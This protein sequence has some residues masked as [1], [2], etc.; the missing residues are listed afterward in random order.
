MRNEAQHNSH[1]KRVFEICELVLAAA[2]GKRGELLRDQ[3][4]DDAALLARVKAMLA[5]ID[6]AEQQESAQ[7]ETSDPFG[8]LGNRANPVK[9][10]D[11]I[12][13]FVLLEHIGSGG[14]GAVFRAERAHSSNAQQVAIKV[15]NAQI[16]TPELRL[17]F[18]I[19][20][21]ILSRLRHPY[22]AG[23]IDGGTI[24][25]G[26][27]YLAME[28]VDGVP[29]DVFCDN[30]R[31][32]VV[33]RLALLEKVAQALQHAHQSLVVHRDIKPSNILVTADG[34]PKLVDFGIAK[35]VSQDPDTVVSNGPSNAPQHDAT[36]Y[37][38]RQALTPDFASPEQLLE[39]KVSTASDTYS[40]GILATMLLTGRRPYE[41]DISSPKSVLATLEA[42]RSWRASGIISQ[43]R[44]QEDLTAIAHS[45]RTTPAK[46]KRRF[47]GDLDTVLAKATHPDAERRYAS[48]AAFGQDIAN[49]RLGKPVVARGDSLGYR[50]WALIRSNRLAFS[51]VTATM[52]ALSVGLAAAL[53]QAE[54]A[55][56]RFHDLHQFSSVVIG[57][58]YNS[59]ADLPGSITTRRLIAQEA[60]HYLDKLASQELDDVA[61]LADLSLAYSRI[62]DVQGRPSS[63]NLGQS[64]L[65]LE[66]YA[67]AQIFA[68][69]I[70]NE[71]TAMRRARAQIYRRK[72]DLLAWQGQVDAAIVELQ[73]S[74]KM[75]QALHQLDPWNTT[76]RVD[77]A[78]NLI[79]LGDRAGHPSFQNIGDPDAASEYYAQAVELLQS[80][81]K[82]STERELLRCLSVALERL[83]TMWLG[84][85]DLVAAQSRFEA[86][87]DIR[88]RLVA[89]HPEH[90]NIRRDAGI[91]IEQI[92]KV[93]QR[94]GDYSGAIADFEGALE[95][96]LSLYALDP[97]DVSAKRTVAI[98]RQNLGSALAQDGD[99]AAARQ[100]LSV[101][102]SLFLELLANDPQAPSLTEKLGDVQDQL[103]NLQ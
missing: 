102:E 103:A 71:T 67:K 100:Q 94:R 21:D 97:D 22:I 83:G 63:A 30:N 90:M 45:R 95:A 58:V 57:E 36:T 51:V 76:A 59:V 11:R 43:V 89:D 35:L 82:S 65:A 53:W 12:D 4:G 69:R 52:V 60:Q 74:R 37:F 3:C 26:A 72:G 24:A 6:D 99:V 98:G 5:R 93:R 46:M 17:R 70:T 68:E 88:L 86:S 92:A 28:L 27:P 55:N 47:R 81:A 85:E 84:K 23:L 7:P 25:T 16:V 62:A 13:D 77:Y 10:G 101:A 73:R 87:R 34:I 2:P 31:L 38:G 64:A 75:L 54:I 20:R 50:T 66:N 1:A 44:S 39:G 49:H 32:R 29:I 41:L 9:A 96:Y 61:L 42:T 18:N 79:N 15:L 80:V 33:E 14:M 78:Y 48:M 91:A 19:E 40:L 8:L 56:N